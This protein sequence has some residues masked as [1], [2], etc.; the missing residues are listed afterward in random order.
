MCLCQREKPK[1]IDTE[2]QRGKSSATFNSF[3]FCGVVKCQMLRQLMYIC[4][5][6]FRSCN[7]LCPYRLMFCI[8]SLF[9]TLKDFRMSLSCSDSVMC[10]NLCSESSAGIT[11]LVLY[12]QC[13]SKSQIS[14][15]NTMVYMQ[16]IVLT[17]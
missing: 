10:S 17:V 3:V 12:S 15:P 4:K 14:S 9:T 11:M 6:I 8:L 2:F 16:T 13:C 5:L 7:K 1:T